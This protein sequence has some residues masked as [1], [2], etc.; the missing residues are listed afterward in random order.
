[1]ENNIIKKQIEAYQSNFLTN[2]NNQLSTYQTEITQ[3]IRL[4][5]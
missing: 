1:M 3:N 2:Q 4:E 5:N